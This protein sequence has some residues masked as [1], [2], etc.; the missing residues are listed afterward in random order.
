MDVL[1]KSALLAV[2]FI[3]VTTG[4]LFAQ[5]R[6]DGSSRSLK[7]ER[8]AAEEKAV[9]GKESLVYKETLSQL[10]TTSQPG[11]PEQP[12][13]TTKVKTLHLDDFVVYGRD[14]TKEVI[15]GQTL[16]G[17]ELKKLTVFSVADAL[18]YFSGVQIKDY[19][20]LGG[21]KTVN[22]R[23]MGTNHMGVFYDGIQ[24]G[25]AQNGQIDLGKFSLDNIEQV[26]LYNGQKSDIFQPAKDF[27]SAGTIYLQTKRPQ[28]KHARKTNLRATLKTGSFGL[29]AP[30][31]LWEQ[32]LPYDFAFNFN[33]E[34]LSS[35]GK[36]PFRYTRVFEDK[37]VAYDTTAIRKNGDIKAIRLES[38]IYKT[39]HEGEWDLRAYFYK[40]HRGLPGPIVKNV[41]EHGQRLHDENFFVQSKLR[42]TFSNLYSLKLNVKYANDYT[43]YIDD[44]W[45]SPTYVD[46][47]YLQHDL[48]ISSA[49]RFTVT[50]WLQFN[51][52]VDYQLNKMEANL[53]NFSFPTRN[54]LLA[55]AAGEVRF[56]WFTLQASAL[57]TF[58]REKVKMN[59][60][61]PKKDIFTPSVILSIKPLKRHELYLQGFYKRI[62]RMPTFNDLYYTFVGNSVLKPEYVTQYNVGVNYTLAPEKSILKSLYFQADAYYNEIDDKIVAVPAGNMFRWMM[63]NLGKVQIKGIEANTG[64]TTEFYKELIGTLRFNYT[65]QHAIDVTDESAKNYRHQIVYIPRHSGSVIA[66]VDYKTWGLNYSFIYTGERYS[67]KYNDVNSHLQPWYTH[68]ISLRKNLPLSAGKHDLRVALDVNNLFNQHYDV[69]LNYPMP[70]RNYRL[71]LT[72]TL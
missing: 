65:Y 29:F 52:S 14:L 43:R 56:D 30:S 42:K 11:T 32:K 48:Y 35:H 69:V 49:N 21:L 53:V 67:A 23:S 17:E 66:S 54:T 9:K 63:L 41:F 19:G 5:N 27:G 2:T 18:R 13:D 7:E 33:T 57:G 37:T 68:D 36:Y 61:A 8:F 15:P 44:E 38:A 1:K 39:L 25:N 60:A 20:G 3:Q 22:I 71:T 16:S 47:Q 12:A 45:T 46:N 62:F 6:H 59:R 58:V 72:A 28:F 70:G 40:S 64:V 51:L 24:L 50:P 55:A 26:T 10:G 31:L 4:M 34:L